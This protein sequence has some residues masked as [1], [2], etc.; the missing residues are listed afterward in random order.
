M[1]PNL[2]AVFIGGHVDGVKMRLDKP[3]EVFAFSNETKSPD[4]EIVQ[5]VQML[6]RLTSHGPPLRYEFKAIVPIPIPN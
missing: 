2:E 1:Q 4:G 3:H 6:Y 5:K